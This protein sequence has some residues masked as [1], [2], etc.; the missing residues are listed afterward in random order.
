MASDGGV[1]DLSER[2]SAEADG[3]MTFA[4]SMAPDVHDTPQPQ[5]VIALLSHG[6][7]VTPA[8]FPDG[9]P[10][11]DVLP[12]VLAEITRTGGNAA[13]DVVFFQRVP[14]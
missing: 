13:A 6:A 12:R 1:H 8:A 2:V 11:A 9:A 14:D 7:L 5:M 3:S 10:A 4:F